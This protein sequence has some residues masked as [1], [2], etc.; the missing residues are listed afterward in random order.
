MAKRAKR[1]VRRS[2]IGWLAVKHKTESQWTIGT[3]WTSKRIAAYVANVSGKADRRIVRV[4]ITQ[5]TPQRAKK[6]RK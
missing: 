1:K 3:V 5:L 6:G 2:W 4:K